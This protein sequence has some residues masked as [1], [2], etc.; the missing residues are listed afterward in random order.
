MAE[1]RKKEAELAKER[2]EYEAYIAQI[3]LAAAKIDENAYD[4]ALK[5][6]RES[7]SELRNWEWGR[8]MHL[9]Q[10]GAGAYTAPGPVVSVAYSPDGKSFVTGDQ[11]GLVTVRDADTG[12]ERFKLPHGQYVLSVDYSPDGKRIASGSSDKTIKI[13]DAANGRVID[14]LSGHTDGVLSVRFS[15]GGDQLLSG[16]Y[17]KTARLWDVES[18]NTLQEFKGHSWWVWSVDFS[19]DASRIVTAG[20]DGKAIVWQKAVSRQPSVPSPQPSAPLPSP[21]PPAPSPQPL[22]KRANG[23]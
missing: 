20:Q 8:L 3:G 1:D 14:T 11:G 6:L 23:T 19:P 4:S 13:L 2:E 10:L 9:S 17:D 16:S 5:L 22:A 21:Q 15:P 7:K 18:G 12:K